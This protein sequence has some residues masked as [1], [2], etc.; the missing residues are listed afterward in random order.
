[1]ANFRRFR[2]LLCGER[3]FVVVENPTLVSGLNQLPGPRLLLES[4]HAKPGSQ[5]L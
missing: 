2:P 4:K 3:D 1:V 5:D